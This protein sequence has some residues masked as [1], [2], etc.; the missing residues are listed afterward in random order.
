MTQRARRVEL[1]PVGPVLHL[2]A[3]FSN[4]RVARV[5][6][7]CRLGNVDVGIQARIVH[8]AAG[9][10]ERERRNEQARAGNDPAI[11]R[12][13][14]RDVCKTRAFAVDVTQGRKSGF[15]ILSRGS[16]ALHGTKGLRFRDDRRRATLVLR[17]QQDVRVAIDQTGQ[18]RIGRQV[19]HACAVGDL[20]VCSDPFDVLAADDDDGISGDGAVHRVEE[21]TAAN[22]RNAVGSGRRVRQCEQTSE[23]YCREAFQDS[24]VG[25]V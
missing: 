3:Y 19:D 11:D 18:N 1:Y 21:P 14:Y 12:I 20:R 9:D 23:R 10:R 8:V 7:R 24:Y 13:A 2:A 17:L 4:H 5:R 6:E 22:R 15:K 25:H 16:D